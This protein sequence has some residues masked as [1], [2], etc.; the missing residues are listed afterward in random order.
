LAVAIRDSSRRRKAVI[1]AGE[2]HHNGGS[3]GKS[4]FVRLLELRDR[5]RTADRC[6]G[7]QTRADKLRCKSIERS[8]RKTIERQWRRYRLESLA[9]DG[10]QQGI[11]R[12][13]AHDGGGFLTIRQCEVRFDAGDLR[14]RKLRAFA[15]DA[16]RFAPFKDGDHLV[17]R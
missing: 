2:L 14:E 8:L 16:V 7:K 10:G 15:A 4:I 6:D 1:T 12:H 17:D 13:S 11:C 9:G 5:R 3:A